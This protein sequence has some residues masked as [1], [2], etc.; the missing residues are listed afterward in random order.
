MFESPGLLRLARLQPE[1]TDALANSYRL[2]IESLDP[3]LL[4]LCVECIDASLDQ[5]SWT[6]P[7]AMSAKARAFIDFTEQFVASVSSLTVQQ[8]DALKPHATVDEIYLFANALYV[9]EMTRRVER[10]AGSILSD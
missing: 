10:V 3:E 7:D 4:S 1:S 2:A 9:L 5:R 6:R 8:V